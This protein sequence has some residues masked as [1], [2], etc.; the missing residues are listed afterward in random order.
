M[1]MHEMGQYVWLHDRTS[2]VDPMASIPHH[3]LKGGKQHQTVFF[4]LSWPETD[5]N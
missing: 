2:N 1:N 4:V 5:A 3:D